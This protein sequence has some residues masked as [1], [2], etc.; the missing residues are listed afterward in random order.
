MYNYYMCL[1]MEPIKHH[2]QYYETSVWLAF[3]YIY[4][5]DATFSEAWAYITMYSTPL[6]Y[7]T[8]VQ[9]YID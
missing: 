2:I 5:L 1:Y 6:F 3:V 7:T 8:T 9:Y 4:K